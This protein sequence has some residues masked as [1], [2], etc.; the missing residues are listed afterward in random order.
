MPLS[1][2]ILDVVLVFLVNLVAVLLALALVTVVI[3]RRLRSSPLLGAAGAGS[4]SGLTGNVSDDP[5]QGTIAPTQW[6][7][8]GGGVPGDGGEYSAADLDLDL[9]DE[10]GDGGE[11]EGEDRPEFEGQEMGT[12]VPKD[13]PGDVDE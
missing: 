6:T 3:T 13:P 1:L 8:T 10:D 4:G 5:D 12:D 2:T 9:E 11:D 7:A